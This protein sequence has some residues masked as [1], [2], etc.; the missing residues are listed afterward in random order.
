MRPFKYHVSMFLAFSRP[1]HSPT[2]ARKNSTVNQ[3]KMPFS[4]PLCRCHL[5]PGIIKGHLSLC[6]AGQEN[7]ALLESLV[8]GPTLSYS[9]TNKI[10]VR[11]ILFRLRKQLKFDIPN[12]CTDYELTLLYGLCWICLQ[13]Y[14]SIIKCVSIL[15]EY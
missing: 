13:F 8:S 11:A 1:T 6:P 10:L 5:C 14:S 9:D 15:K 2:Y 4:D 12:M 7:S 3:Q